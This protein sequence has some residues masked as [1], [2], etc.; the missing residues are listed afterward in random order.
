M[1]FD[2]LEQGYF[3]ISSVALH[4]SMLC[5][6]FSFCALPYPRTA[7]SYRTL[8]LYPS[9]V[10]LATSTSSDVFISYISDPPVLRSALTAWRTPSM[11]APDPDRAVPSSAIL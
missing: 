4:A 6:N 11:T 2:W 7:P 9:T 8:V 3:V 10:F 5:K 1:H